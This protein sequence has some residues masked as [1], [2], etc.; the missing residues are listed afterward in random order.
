MS[1][2]LAFTNSGGREFQILTILSRKK[3][4]MPIVITDMCLISYLLCPLVTEVWGGGK[5]RK[6]HQHQNHTISINR[7]WNTILQANRI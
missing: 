7:F 3:F 1:I 5:T 6:K 2:D 4:N